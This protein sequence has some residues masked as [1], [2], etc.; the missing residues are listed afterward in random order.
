MSDTLAHNQYPGITLQLPESRA[1][2]VSTPLHKQMVEL[3]TEAS[4]YP[5]GEIGVLEY[6]NQGFRRSVV[7]EVSMPGE[8]EEPVELAIVKL[9]SAFNN[10]S[11]YYLVGLG[12]DSEGRPQAREDRYWVPLE[13]NRPVTL[14]R[15]HSAVNGERLVGKPYGPH[16][17][18]RHATVTYSEGNIIIEDS[19]SN[20]SSF[21][22]QQANKATAG[23]E[24]ADDSYDYDSS[25]T[26]NA[27]ELA[28]MKGLQTERNGFVNRPTIG[29]DTFP[30]EG[31]VDIR[32]WLAGG[33]AI[34]VDSTKNAEVYENLRQELYTALTAVIYEDQAN[35]RVMS[36][37]QK[38][39]EAIYRTVEQGMTY[40]LGYANLVS[41]YYKN[42]GSEERI[43]PLAQYIQAR[44]GVCRHMALTASWLGGEASRIGWAKGRFTTEV[45]Q[46]T[47]GNGA[48]EWARY[49]GADGEVYIIDPAQRFRGKLIDT[50]DKAPEGH[51]RW[52][53]F[54]DKAERDEFRQRKLGARITSAAGYMQLPVPG[55][56]I[57][58]N[59]VPR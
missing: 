29:R 16:V 27:N 17:S 48:H 28:R 47:Q 59:N 3:S 11:K 31:H 8:H 32:A 56:V 9:S 12:R 37:D 7:G 13:D 54:R 14:G 38:V 2:T 51:E 5:P 41:D 25:H 58:T 4:L 24:H 23:M 52:G 33:E 18:K 21:K 26:M 20:G 40:D 10:P 55:R 53:Y 36:D 46:S 19:S 57:D 44:K 35:G 49:V 34:E 22:G 50:L 43:V 1:D 30:I 6:T 39:V 15:D 45:N 42:I